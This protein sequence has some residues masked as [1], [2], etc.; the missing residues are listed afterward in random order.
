MRNFSE[1][2]EELVGEL[3]EAMRQHSADLDDDTRD[4]IAGV[5]DDLTENPAADPI[6]R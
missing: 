3:S 1:A 6:A 2:S 5:I 4:V